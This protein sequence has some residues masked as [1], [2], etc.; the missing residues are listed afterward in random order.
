MRI[1]CPYCEGRGE[2]L[3]YVETA[4][5]ETSVT[6]KPK[7]DI[8]RKCNG[9]GETPKTNADH[10]RAMTDEELAKALAEECEEREYCYGCFAFKDDG[11]CP[12]QS[13]S[14]WL[15]WLQQPCEGD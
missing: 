13:I 6:V 10:I 9:S 2:V 5:D 3:Y 15:E 12:G 11:G 14:A 4:R 7:Y 1:R 8:C